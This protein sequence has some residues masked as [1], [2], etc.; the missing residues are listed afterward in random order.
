MREETPAEKFI[1]FKN[2][3]ASQQSDWF[4]YMKRVHDNKYD[5]L[6]QIH[7]DWASYQN[8]NSRDW[9]NNTNCSS[10]QKDKIFTDQLDRAV[11]LYRN[12]MEQFKKLC[13]N[14]RNEAQQIQERHEEALDSFLGEPKSKKAAAEEAK[15]PM[16]AQP[17]SRVTVE[18]VIPTR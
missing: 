6:K 3:K 8:Q 1:A 18:R 15:R 5:L 4:D 7:T 11:T 14:E 12:N 9:Q 10:E 13:E 17:M 2:L 16:P